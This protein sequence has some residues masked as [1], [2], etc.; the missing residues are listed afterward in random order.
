MVPTEARARGRKYAVLDLRR[1]SINWQPNKFGWFAA[2][3]LQQTFAAFDACIA[4]AGVENH[5]RHI[6]RT[7][8]QRSLDHVKDRPRCGTQ[9][10]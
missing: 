8:C 2:G 1:V 4:V 7:R 3:V 5:F 9:A 10:Q 6:L